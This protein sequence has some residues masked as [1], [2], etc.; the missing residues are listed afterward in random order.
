MLVLLMMSV[1]TSPTWGS[2]SKAK[3]HKVATHKH[4]RS[5]QPL[6]PRMIKVLVSRGYH[7]RRTMCMEASAYVAGRCG[8]SKSGSTTSGM[9]AGVG[10]VAVDPR[11]VRLGTRL[12]VEG[13]GPCIAGDTGGSIKG[14]KIDL[15]YKS[16]R[17]A[18]QFGRRNVIVH[19]LGGK[20]I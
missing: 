19:I 10:V 4:Y 15:G 16:Y 12:Y 5:R 9:R 3:T 11:V 2:T 1:L 18:I 8:G 13:Y 17:S 6:K 14:N 7:I 20:R